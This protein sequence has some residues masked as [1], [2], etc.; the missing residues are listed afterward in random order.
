RIIAWLA[1]GQ[2]RLDSVL[3][4]IAGYGGNPA[5]AVR[6]LRGQPEFELASSR[7]RI[8]LH[9]D[10]YTFADPLRKQHLESLEVLMTHVQAVA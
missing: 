7:L 3:R 5:A 9:L 8:I 1:P 4:D 2:R 10:R 6:W